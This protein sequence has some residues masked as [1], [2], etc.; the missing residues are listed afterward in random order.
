MDDDEGPSHENEIDES[1]SLVERVE[2]YCASGTLVQRLVFVRELASCAEDIGVSE[3][4]GRLVPLLKVIVCDPEQQVRQVRMRDA[5]I[6]RALLA[7][8]R[9]PL[10]ALL[11]PSSRRACRPPLAARHRL[12]GPR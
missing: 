12:A 5:S 10:H 1:L 3:A 11:A 7:A 4:V 9:S 8:P 2:R 6:S